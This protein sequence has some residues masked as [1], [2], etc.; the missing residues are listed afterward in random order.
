MPSGFI[1][2]IEIASPKVDLT[3]GH[4][5][6]GMSARAP[7]TTLREAVVVVCL[8]AKRSTSNCRSEGEADKSSS[9]RPPANITCDRFE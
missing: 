9:V 5:M 1:P 7:S 8:G 4:A 2:R 6:S 3:A